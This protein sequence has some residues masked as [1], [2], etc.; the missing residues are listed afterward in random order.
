[1]KYVR[2]D[3]VKPFKVKILRYVK[4][5]REMHD[6]AKYLHPPLMKVESAEADNWTVRNQDF[7]TG[8][9][10]LAI[11]DGIPKSMQD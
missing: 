1:M 9:V 4:R 11:K 6:L 3:I 7:A 2:N 8:E 5:V 10:Q